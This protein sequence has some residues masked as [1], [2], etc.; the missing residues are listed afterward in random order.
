[1]AH[2][3]VGVNIQA[4]QADPTIRKVG[5]ADL[6]DAFVGSIADSNKKP[7]DV[8]PPNLIYPFFTLIVLVIVYNPLCLLFLIAAS[9][10]FKRSPCYV[11]PL[12]VRISS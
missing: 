9:V 11:R 10:T 5:T 2:Q 1:M 12:N 8:R 4:V 6:R 7:S 3:H